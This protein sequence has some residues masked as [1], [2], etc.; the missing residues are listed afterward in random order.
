MT[1]HGTILLIE[2]DANEVLLI[3]KALAELE[4][5]N[6]VQT[7]YVAADAIRYLSGDGVYEN[8]ASF[9]LPFLVLLD[10]NMPDE[11]GFAVLRWLH[12]RPGLRKKF[13][14]IVLSAASPEPEI[15]LAYE[16]GAQSFLLKPLEYRQLVGCFRRIKE[17][18]I[19]LNV[20][21]G[22]IAG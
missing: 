9:P 13:N 15:Q 8:R 21:P 18:W 4:V 12:E 3:K 19:D 20:M 7:V 16:L 14:L 5:C 6:P 22:D 11:G 17:Y 2:D 10:L 1:R